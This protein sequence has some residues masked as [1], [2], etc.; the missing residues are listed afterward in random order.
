MQYRSDVF[1]IFFGRIKKE[2]RKR[3]SRVMRCRE[4]NSP[5]VV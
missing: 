4:S 2:M 3:V 1:G 5:C